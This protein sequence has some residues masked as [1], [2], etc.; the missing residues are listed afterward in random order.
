[1]RLAA[2]WS[3][4]LES[5]GRAIDELRI[6]VDGDERDV[7]ARAELARVLEAA[8]R[9]PEAITEHL[10][11]LRLEPLRVDSLRALRRLCE[12]AGQRRRAL[13]AA[14]ALVALGLAEPTTRAPCA[15]AALR[16]APEATGSDHRRRVRQPTSAIPTSATPRPR[17]WR[18][19]PRCCRASTA[20]RW[21]T[22]G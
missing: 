12:R 1:M 9:L 21:R 4:P 17:C 6:V 10:A 15:R 5:S 16:W 7:E 19:C 18:R 8:E 2:F 11:L 20:W 14:A 3:G 22:G 13:R